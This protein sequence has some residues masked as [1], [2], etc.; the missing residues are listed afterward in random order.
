M[1]RYF[2]ISCVLI[3]APFFLH[4]TTIDELL[5]QIDIL[6]KQALTL[7]AQI[8]T[9]STTSACVFTRDLTVGSVGADVRCLQQFLN[10]AGFLVAR[11]GVGSP[12]FETDYF[13]NLTQQAVSAWQ[14]NLSIEPAIGYFGNISRMRFAQIE[15]KNQTN[16]QATETA[17][18]IEKIAPIQPQTKTV[19]PPTIER[20]TPQSVAPGEYITIYGGGYTDDNSVT[21]VFTLL[22]RTY[23]HI[24][25]P[26]GKTLTIQYFPPETNL[27]GDEESRILADTL[28]REQGYSLAQVLQSKS[29]GTISEP[30]KILIINK[31]GETTSNN[32]QFYGKR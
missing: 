1:I 28:L 21:I 2:F 7:S 23:E 17:E 5:A 4:A 22:T 8:K 19:Q 29:N 24:A 6:Q 9:L 16:N 25:S 13:G 3:L 30:Y 18:M 10:N 32:I 31:N 27:S 11:T 26:D 15:Q 14:K 20:V 12:G